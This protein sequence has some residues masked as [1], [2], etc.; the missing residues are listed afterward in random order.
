M[1]A[2]QMKEASEAE[3]TLE[4]NGKEVEVLV[5]YLYSGQA[6]EYVSEDILECAIVAHKFGGMLLLLFIPYLWIFALSIF[7]NL[8]ISP[9]VIILCYILIAVR[10]F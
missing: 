3:I 6:E 1:L 7:F 2:G 4:E 10:K 8:C 9:D 5:Q